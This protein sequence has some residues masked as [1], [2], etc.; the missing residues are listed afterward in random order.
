MSDLFF[1]T[2]E[3]SF[4]LFLLGC[5]VGSFLNV[6]ILRY[7]KGEQA[8]KGRSHCMSCGK[9]L[10]W[11]ELV[12]LFSFLFQRG[13]CRE[14]KTKLSLQYPL[15]E[16][17]TGI[18]FFLVF[19]HLF[20]F[21]PSEAV[22]TVITSGEKEFL[23]KWGGLLIVHLVIWSLFMVI[24]VYDIRTKLIPNRFSYALAG[25]AFLALFLGEQ[26][27]AFTPPTLSEVVA[28]P[29]LFL[30]FYALWKVSD[31]RWLGLGDG[32]LALGIGWFLGLTLG[33][34]AILFAF[35]IGA[36]VSLLYIF[37]QKLYVSFWKRGSE[38]EM[39]TLKSE[40]PFG[41]FLVLA[42]LIVY[43]TQFNI[44]AYLL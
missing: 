5:V 42:T 8:V 20:P 36:S 30:P 23:M 22:L 6:I 32:K 19:F 35:W 1:L 37:F 31:G 43:V 24:T 12:P 34:T 17:G 29:A 11:Y 21:L 38:K 39:L 27:L 2:F 14:C 44:Y 40:I 41:P 9:T 10:A 4:F 33:G 28:G 26:S 13:R 25:V 7:E 18:L 3:F 15:V 16:L